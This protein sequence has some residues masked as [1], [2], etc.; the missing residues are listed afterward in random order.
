MAVIQRKTIDEIIHKR[1]GDV[2]V[3]VGD[4]SVTDVGDFVGGFKNHRK[5]LVGDAK[6]W[7]Y[8]A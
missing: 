8:Q 1:D 4:L 7:H 3:N 6:S 5:R 2:G